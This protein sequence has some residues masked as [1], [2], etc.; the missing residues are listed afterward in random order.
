MIDKASLSV[1]VYVDYRQATDF[2]MY[3]AKNNFQTPFHD[4]CALVKSVGNQ[5]VVTDKEDVLST[6][7]CDVGGNK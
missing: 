1:Y 6:S 5:S 4:M 2:E 7:V 3:S